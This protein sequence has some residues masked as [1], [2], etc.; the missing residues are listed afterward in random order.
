MSGIDEYDVAMVPQSE[1]DAKD[2]E[3]VRL[4]QAITRIH[5]LAVEDADGAYSTLICEIVAEAENAILGR[6]EEGE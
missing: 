3:I 6:P 5:R 2:A 1:L 4:R